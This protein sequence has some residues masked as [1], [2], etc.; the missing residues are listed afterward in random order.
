[1]L[2][3][4]ILFLLDLT[5]RSHLIIQLARFPLF[6]GSD[7][8][9]AFRAIFFHV[10]HVFHALSALTTPSIVV[11]TTTFSFLIRIQALYSSNPTEK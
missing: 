11:I 3:S 1:M 9:F 2:L 7:D 10:F 6:L 4:I 8:F 5:H